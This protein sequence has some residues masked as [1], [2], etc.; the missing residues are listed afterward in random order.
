MSDNELPDFELMEFLNRDKSAPLLDD[1]IPY[2]LDESRL[3]EVCEKWL[4]FQEESRSEKPVTQRN[5]IEDYGE[6]FRILCD[7]DEN[8]IET[9]KAMVP[10]RE[11]LWEN[12]TKSWVI[13]NNEYRD[14]VEMVFNMFYEWTFEEIE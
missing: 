10:Y 9:L 1:Y 13:T 5:R 7:Y 8:F 3:V 11:R 4:R 14:Q 12:S 6:G 2:E